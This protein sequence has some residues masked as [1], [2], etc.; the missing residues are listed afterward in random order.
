MADEKPVWRR[1]SHC[2]PLN[3]V[4]LTFVG[5][6]VWVRDSFDR[7]GQILAIRVKNWTHFLRHV[8]RLP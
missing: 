3:C 7:D 6:S 1:S 5:D 4:E 8:R 2:D